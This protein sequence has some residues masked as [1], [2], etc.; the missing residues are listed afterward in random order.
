VASVQ[1]NP[2]FDTT[3]HPSSTNP[4]QFSSRWTSQSSLAAGVAHAGS[5]VPCKDS[6]ARWA[7]TRPWPYNTLKPCASQNPSSASTLSAVWFRISLTWAA[8]ASG[9]SENIRAA[10]PLTTGAA[11]DVPPNAEV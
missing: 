10:T 2:T 1:S 3:E 8:V 11:P 7:F 5:L 6:S 9:F 4:S